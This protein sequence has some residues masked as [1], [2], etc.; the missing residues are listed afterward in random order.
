MYA[1]S[2]PNKFQSKKHL[3]NLPQK[4]LFSEINTRWNPN[5]QDW[6][7]VCKYRQSCKKVATLY[8]VGA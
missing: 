8:T 2:N 7:A 1:F 5:E 4:K 3:E 6:E